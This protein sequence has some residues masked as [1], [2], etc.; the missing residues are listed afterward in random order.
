MGHP[1]LRWVTVG[2]AVANLVF[3]PLE[4]LLFLFIPE[5]LDSG[6]TPPGFLEF[7]FADE[8]LVG[9]FIGLQAAVGS[10]LIFTGPRLAK[11]A[12]LGRMF[13]AGLALFGLGFIGMVFS[14][15]FWGFIPAGLGVGG[16]GFANIAIVTMRQRLAPPEMLGR[17]VAA[18][19]TISWS[20]IPLGAA[21]GGALADWVGLLPVYL[22]GSCGVIITALALIRTE[23]WSGHGLNS[24]GR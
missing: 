6:I 10:A 14:G 15:S 7:L 24:R 21:L 9:L 1:Q 13:T 11:R 5:Y 2:A 4:A 16:V 22:V 17:V 12:H 8:A 3:A 19:R 23:V 20:L 18:S